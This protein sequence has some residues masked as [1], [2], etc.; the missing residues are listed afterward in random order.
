MSIYLSIY[1]Y[2][3][4]Y[5][6]I[7]IHIYIY[8]YV[9]TYIY[10]YVS[11]LIAK[12]MSLGPRSIH[13]DPQGILRQVLVGQPE[14]GAAPAPKAVCR[15]PNCSAFQGSMGFP[16]HRNGGLRIYSEWTIYWMIWTI[17]IY[18]WRSPIVMGVPNSWMVRNGKSHLYTWMI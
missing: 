3:Y 4:I 9:Y 1:L 11:L 14:P 6:H 15:C 5:I 16:S 12:S 13:Q 2:L 18:I 10:M 7:Y 8:M 17:W